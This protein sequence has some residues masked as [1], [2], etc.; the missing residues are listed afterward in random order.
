[1][2]MTVTDRKA[3]RRIPDSLPPI[4]LHEVMMELFRTTPTA[5][6]KQPKPINK[7]NS[8]RKSKELSR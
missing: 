7:R 2:N 1:M 5:K 8:A 6:R 3:D 4:S